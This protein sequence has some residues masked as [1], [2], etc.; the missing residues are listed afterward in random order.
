MNT[1]YFLNCVSGNVFNTKTSPALPSVYY[2]GLSTTTP[3]IDGS[4]VTEPITGTGYERV[5]L[6]S[7]SEPNAGVVTNNDIINFP[8]STADWGTVTHFVI[9]DSETVGEGNLLMFGELSVP[10]SVETATIV[11]IKEGYLKLS[12][13][14]PE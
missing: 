5:Q 7:L 1:T 3:S 12:V 4:G 11:T 8:E 10:R 6:S 14:N 2:I 9:Y 13:Q